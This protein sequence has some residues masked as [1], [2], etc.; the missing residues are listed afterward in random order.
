M[1]KPRNSASTPMRFSRMSKRCRSWG[2]QAIAPSVAPA[3]GSSD[4]INGARNSRASPSLR[5]D[6]SV[7]A[8]ATNIFRA[9]A[10]ASNVRQKR[11]I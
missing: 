11:T 8:L 3:A 9:P 4:W 10:C 5:P 6:S 7:S 1:T 2:S